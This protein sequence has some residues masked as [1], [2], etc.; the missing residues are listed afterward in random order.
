MCYSNEYIS[1][2]SP[3]SDRK[4][5][6][7]SSQPPASKWSRQ[8]SILH[9]CRMLLYAMYWCVLPSSVSLHIQSVTD[10]AAT[11]EPPSRELILSL[12]VVLTLCAHLRLCH[13]VCV[14]VCVDRVNAPVALYLPILF[15]EFIK[16]LAS[17]QCSVGWCWVFSSG[18]Y[19]CANGRGAHFFVRVNIYN[20][21]YMCSQNV[22]TW[23]GS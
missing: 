10:A 16:L 20:V 6:F 13:S 14:C 12:L 19:F 22:D 4:G 9:M 3:A 7:S 15:Q 8:V 23:R 2:H 11:Q 17:L 21:M 18:H 1:I 5:K